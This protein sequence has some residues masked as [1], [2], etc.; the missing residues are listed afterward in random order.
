MAYYKVTEKE[1]PEWGVSKVNWV[2]YVRGCNYEQV[3]QYVINNYGLL[4]HYYSM[5]RIKV[6]K[7]IEKIKVIDARGYER[8]IHEDK[9]Q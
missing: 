5:D 9:R 4:E 1:I 6:T 2:I 3:A 7:T 8:N